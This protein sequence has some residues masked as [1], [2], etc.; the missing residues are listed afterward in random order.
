MKRGGGKAKGAQ[1]EREICQALSGWLTKGKRRDLFWRSAMSGGRATV[2]HRKGVKLTT[3]GGD[4]SAIDPDG[5]VLTD[6]FCIE[7]KFYKD[8]DFQAFLMGRG[9]LQR[10][11]EQATRDAERYGKEPMLIAKQNQY[12][13]LVLVRWGTISSAVFWA[14]VWKWRSKDNDLAI[15]LFDDLMKQTYIAPAIVRYRRRS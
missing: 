11:W 2:A 7:L 13:T 3:Q 4:I 1:F 15:G 6:R 12:P 9:K 8:L 10:F 5:A 14:R